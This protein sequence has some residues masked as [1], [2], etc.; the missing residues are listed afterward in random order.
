MLKNLPSSGAAIAAFAALLALLG[1]EREAGSSAVKKRAP[2]AA[3]AAASVTAPNGA[4]EN[5]SETDATGRREGTKDLGVQQAG[6][7]LVLTRVTA[8]KLLSA[9]KASGKKGTVV[10]AWA[11]W[12]GPCRREVPMLQALSV[13]LKP[14]GV[15]IVL[16][17]V[18]EPKDEAKALSFLKDNGITL[19]SYV[20]DGD[21]GDFK[22]GMNPNWPGMLPASFL[23]DRA[24]QLVHFWGGEAFENEITPVIDNFVAGRP[25][26]A[27]TRYGLAP[28]KVE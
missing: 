26:E 12:C 28:G 14:Q 24:A 9:I 22:Q 6:G 11:S 20:V 19:A 13:N 4:V 10:N 23:F 25:V 8:A 16:V 27:E 17:S 18:D 2:A 7:D 5:E 3:A 1:C 21:M 15:Q